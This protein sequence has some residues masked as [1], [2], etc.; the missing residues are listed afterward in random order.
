MQ[1]G[2][3]ISPVEVT[4]VSKH[5]FWM[6]I[7]EREVFLPFEKFPWFRNL[8]IG[9]LRNVTLPQP[10]HLYWPDLDV[11]LA[12]EPIDHPEKFPLVSNWRPDR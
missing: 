4:N 11:D 10:H 12:V 2:T 6:L 1:S 9:P 3:N 7:G 8:P 5:G